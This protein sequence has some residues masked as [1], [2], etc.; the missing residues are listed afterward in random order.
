MLFDNI[1]LKK[2]QHNVEGKAGIQKNI[3]ESN[4]YLSL[5]QC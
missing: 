2:R 3:V 1:K 4:V 5:E